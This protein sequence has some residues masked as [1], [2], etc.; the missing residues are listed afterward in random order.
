MTRKP[1]PPECF[2]LVVVGAGHAG[3]E[4]AMAASGLG[5]STLLLTGNIDH[6]GQLSC[7]PAV[8]GL[9]KGHMVREIDAL[10]GFMGI[11]ADAS[12]IQFRTL[13]TSKGPAVRSTRAQM[14]RATYQKTVSSSL[15]S[16]QNLW[17]RQA[18]V[19]GIQ[20]DNGRVCGVTTLLGETILA[21]F[22]LLT[23]GTFLQG[24]IHVGLRNFSGGRFGDA[25]CQGLSVTLR[26]LGLE[27]GRLKT[28]TVPRL[29]RDSVD[30]DLLEPQPGDDPPPRF[31]FH[32]PGPCLPQVPCFV[33]WTNEAT[34]ETIRAG[35]DRSP[36]FQG[37]ITGI[38]ARYCPSIED[39]VAR[40]P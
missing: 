15:F 31:S 39:K 2:D 26:N 30:F 25:A 34:H 3:S 9:A 23:T 8:G 16:R 27:L 33:T 20:V 38:G 4:A 11:W 1:P 28:G 36:L 21:R 17:V 37:V 24:L 6:I 18:T 35:F 10:G 12:G 40:F 32:G 14:D 22:V 13:N 19:E 29:L 5:L 7:N